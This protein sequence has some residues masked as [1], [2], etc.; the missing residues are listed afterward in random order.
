[1]IALD[2]PLLALLAGVLA[3]LAGAA[4]GKSPPL[5]TKRAEE[6]SAA[7]RVIVGVLVWHGC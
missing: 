4:L 1:M 5:G 7:N 6:P 3:L 2:A